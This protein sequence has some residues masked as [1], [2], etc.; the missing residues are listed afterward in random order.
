MA[1]DAVEKAGM[2]VAILENR[3]ITLLREKLPR[4]SAVNNP[5]D[6][7]G[8]ADPERYASAIESAQKDASVDAILVIMTPQTMSYPA[9]TALAIAEAIDGSKPV[10]ASFMGGS[11][12][13]P[14]RDE[15]SAAGLPDYDSPERA[16]AALRAMHQY[17]LWKNRPPRQITHFRVN[18]RRVERIITRRLRTGRLTVGEIKGKDILSAYGFKIPTGRLAASQE[19][20]VEIAER[21][22]YPVALKIVSPTII[23]KSDLGGI[24]LEPLQRRGGRGCLR[25]DDAEDQAAGTHRS[26]RRDLRRADDPSRSG[27]NSGHEPRSAIRPDADVWPGRYFR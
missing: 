14:G 11:D 22:G 20:A 1:A 10:V 2:Q 16:V 19:E 3:T 6:V 7:L 24:Q 8:D 17:A 12:V 27:G 5:I 9:A 25:P 4:E 15:L 13:L 21:I 26:D 23:H 18:R